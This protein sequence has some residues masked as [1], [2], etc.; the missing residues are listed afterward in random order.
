MQLSPAEVDTTGITVTVKFSATAKLRLVQF[1]TVIVPT[2]TPTIPA[3]PA[4][5]PTSVPVPTPKPMPTQVTR[6]NIAWY[7]YYRDFPPPCSGY[8]KKR[9]AF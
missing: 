9:E 5:V 1:P 4:V 3:T 8:N 6:R 2:A 7:P